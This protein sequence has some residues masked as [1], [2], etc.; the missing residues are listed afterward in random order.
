MGTRREASAVAELASF[1]DWAAG[2]PLHIAAWWSPMTMDVPASRD[3]VKT[4]VHTLEVV[5]LLSADLVRLGMPMPATL[6]GRER[7]VRRLGDDD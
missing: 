5:W 7:R 1:T 6:T 2:Y 4:K 3:F